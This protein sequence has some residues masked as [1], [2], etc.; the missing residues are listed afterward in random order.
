M[1]ELEQYIKIAEE[2]NPVKPIKKQLKKI[3]SINPQRGHKCF[4][5][6]KLTSEIIEAEY[7]DGYITMISNINYEKKKK[8]KIKENCFYITALNK[9]NALKKY[10]QIFVK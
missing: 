9:Q 3:G 6:N 4:E 10:K 5:I 1:K 8:L 7:F 2:I